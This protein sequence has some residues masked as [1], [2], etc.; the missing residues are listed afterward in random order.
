MKELSEK[1]LF[2]QKCAELQVL[3]WNIVVSMFFSNLN[4]NFITDFNKKYIILWVK[5]FPIII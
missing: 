4:S 5:D 3:K 2:G 1:K